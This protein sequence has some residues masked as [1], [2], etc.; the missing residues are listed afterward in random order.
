MA[1]P[2]VAAR[3]DPES[4]DSRAIA[5][6][7]CVDFAAAV[8][9]DSSVDG[10]SRTQRIADCVGGW[11]KGESQELRDGVKRGVEE[12]RTGVDNVGRGLEW[13]GGKLRR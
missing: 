3:T 2:E 4:P 6:P 12:F 11:L 5:K 13:L 9:S 1:V 8:R 7:T 10:R